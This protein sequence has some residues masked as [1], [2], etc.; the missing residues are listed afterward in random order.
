MPKRIY[1]LELHTF[2]TEP[3]CWHDKQE[4]RRSLSTHGSGDGYMTESQVKAYRKNHHLPSGLPKGR[5]TYFSR[6]FPE[7]VVRYI[8]D[9]YVGTGPTEMAGKLN[10]AFETNYTVA[11][12]TG[13]TAII[14]STAALPAVFEKGHVPANKGSI[15]RR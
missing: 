15:R 11:Q 5:A 6:I 10:A 2:I 8:M 7:P 9:N 12:S 1:P 4:A 13:I 14:I 3:R